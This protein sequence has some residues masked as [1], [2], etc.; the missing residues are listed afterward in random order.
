MLQNRISGL[1]VVDEKGELVGVVTEG[2]FLRRREIGTER[3]RP[4]WLE[5][6]LGPGKLAE[7]YVHTS[8]RKVEEI[9]TPRSLD[10]R[11]RRRAGTRR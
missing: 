10:R 5:F 11:R 9:M 2:D 8:G 4:K 1:P 7:E 3:Q 6:V